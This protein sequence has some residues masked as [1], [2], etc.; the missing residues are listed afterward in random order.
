[1]QKTKTEK[2]KAALKAAFFFSVLLFRGTVATGKTAAEPRR[3]ILPK[4]ARWGRGWGAGG[5]G[6]PSRASGG[7]AP[8]PGHFVIIRPPLEHFQFE[9]LR[10]SNHTACRFAEKRGFSAH[11]GP[12][13]AVPPPRVSPFSKLKRSR[14]SYPESS[15]AGACPASV[16][17]GRT[18]P[19]S[20]PAGRP[21]FLHLCRRGE[22]CPRGPA[23][24]RRLPR[25]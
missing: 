16:R 22:P 3:C 6:T 4:K 17:D 20:G 10:I 14:R 19:E 11:F 21:R 23:H 13:G 8:S 7:G 1:M 9:M 15:D 5:R 18:W 25:A 12:G 24:R 2:K